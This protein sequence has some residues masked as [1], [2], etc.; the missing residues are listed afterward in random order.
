M[1]LGQSNGGLKTNRIFY[2][3]FKRGWIN[4]VLKKM[5]NVRNESMIKF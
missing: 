1:A 5:N 2:T 4:S 3:E